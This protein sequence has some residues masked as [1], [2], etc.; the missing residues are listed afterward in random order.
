VGRFA[1][2][3]YVPLDGRFSGFEYFYY[4]LHIKFYGKVNGENGAIR[5]EAFSPFPPL[6]SPIFCPG[7]WSSLRPLVRFKDHKPFPGFSDSTHL[8]DHGKISKGY[9]PG[10]AT[11]QGFDPMIIATRNPCAN[12]NLRRPPLLALN[13]L[14]LCSRA[15]PPRENPGRRQR[16]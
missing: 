15:P 8:H 10:A 1:Y 11:V 13:G 2:G 14:C 5:L 16:L 6:I 12:W 4:I 3:F 7:L 9:S